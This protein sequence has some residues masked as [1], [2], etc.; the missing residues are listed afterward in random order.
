MSLIYSTEHKDRR[1]FSHVVMW[2][3]IVMCIMFYKMNGTNNSLSKNKIC[4]FHNH[5][6]FNEI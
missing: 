6:M 5:I 2:K 4:L 1:D 3:L